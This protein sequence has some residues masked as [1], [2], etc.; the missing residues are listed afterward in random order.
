MN[1]R[2]RD[3][4]EKRKRRPQDKQHVA[5][6][7]IDEGAGEMLVL[8]LM[9]VL[10]VSRKQETAEDG[11]RQACRGTN[12]GDADDDAEIINAR[13]FSLTTWDVLSSPRC[14]RARWSFEH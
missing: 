8:M 14:R 3:R 13:R 9:L 5:W 7:D 2:G 11:V 12:A 1:K 4:A 6:P 10:M